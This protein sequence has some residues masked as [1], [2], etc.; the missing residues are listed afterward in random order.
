MEA[1]RCAPISPAP[2][3]KAGSP[4]CCSHW[5]TASSRSCC[6]E[7]D[8]P[9][10]I[11]L[12]A[13]GVGCRTSPRPCP[14]RPFRASLPPSPR[15]G[16]QR[17]LVRS[18]VRRQEYVSFLLCHVSVLSPARRGTRR[19]RRI[20]WLRRFTGS[21]RLRPAPTAIVSGTSIFCC[22][23]IGQTT[24][25]AASPARSGG[26]NPPALQNRTVATSAY[27]HHCS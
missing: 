11:P 14:C 22:M 21:P 3:R 12:S 10:A 7:V 8:R 4:A 9:R 18:T 27:D 17:S 24:C 5:S 19:D 15:A 13:W 2:D 20:P 23:M 25:P 6:S 1:P 26:R 16:Q